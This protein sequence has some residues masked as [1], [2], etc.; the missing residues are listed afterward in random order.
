MMT[1]LSRRFLRRWWCRY[2]GH[3]PAIAEFEVQAW[4]QT[5]ENGTV[6]VKTGDRQSLHEMSKGV[7]QIVG[8]TFTAKNCERCHDFLDGLPAMQLAFDG[9][10]TAMV[11]RA[12]MTKKGAP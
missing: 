4:V 12:T 11:C 8:H 3:R 10:T 5:E 7:G 9:F 2:F 1:V 6:T